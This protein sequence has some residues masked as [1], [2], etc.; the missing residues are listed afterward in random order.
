VSLRCDVE[1]RTNIGN[2]SGSR[3][4]T[5]RLTPQSY[6]GHNATGVATTLPKS[7]PV[8]TLQPATAE[9]RHASPWLFAGAVGIYLLAL[10]L[11]ASHRFVH[12]DILLLVLQYGLVL[13]SA[14]WLLYSH[15]INLAR[16][17]KDSRETQP[18]LRVNPLAV[19]ACFALVAIPLS[20]FAVRG[21]V[22]P[23][24]SGYSFQARIYRSGRIM[25]DPLIGATSSVKATP[26]ELHYAN[27]ILRP[28]GWFPKFPPG[29]P[30]VLSLG[31]LIS[32]RWLPNA[33][34]GTLQLVVIA[35]IG[36][37][38]F[39]RDAGTLA[40]VFA[41]LSPF[42]LINS[43]GMMSHALCAL[44]AAAACL[45]L[46][47]AV[48][49]R[50]VRYFAAMFACLAC[51]FQVRPYTAFVVTIVMAS[52]AIWPTRD[53]RKLLVQVVVVGAL[54]GAIA[55]AGVLAYNHTYTGRWLV[56]PYA[57]AAG[58]DAPPELSLNPVVV[59][60]GMAHS[61]PFMLWETLLGSFPFLHLLAAYAVI[62]EDRYRR[63]VAILAAL[64]VALVLAYLLHPEGYA[65]FFGERFHFEAFF[66]LVLLAAR[67]TGL[68]AERWQIRRKGIVFALLVLGV[69]Q[70]GQLGYAVHVLS[71]RGEPYRKIREAVESPDVSGLIFLHDSPGFVAQ[72]LNLNHAD[73]RHASR[74]YLVD[75]NPESRQQWACRYG[76]SQWIVAGYDPS[77]EKAV[78]DSERGQCQD[79]TGQ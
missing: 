74:I 61:G 69:L 30:L 18:L 10:F 37:R 58:V 34:F 2:R 70:I 79:G 4:S 29:W 21:L 33:I 8:E 27:H 1:R 20:W 44:L 76:F 26:A 62:R 52:A 24:E 42:Y 41:A 23:D 72:H 22:N 5:P 3:A 35:A 57:E 16:Q 17:E 53:N 40:V 46:C 55:I 36:S 32:A 15:K 11:R 71:R 73:W 63:E 19:I 68:L 67:G 51:T 7:A 12:S 25:A 75:A 39:S 48:S 6:H 49:T 54:F 14:L 47:V 77:R 50:Q 38:W 43:V 28:F 13:G 59:L 31:Y 78:L 66:A 56:S 9:T 60:R 65:V 64:Y 45:C